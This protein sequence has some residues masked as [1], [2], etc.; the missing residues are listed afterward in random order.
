MY[1]LLLSYK[2]NLTPRSGQKAGDA[3][4]EAAK[5]FQ[6]GNCA[7]FEGSRAYDNAAKSYKRM[8]AKGM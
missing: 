1:N 3:F 8:D 7:K 5:L 6:R 2:H 4:I